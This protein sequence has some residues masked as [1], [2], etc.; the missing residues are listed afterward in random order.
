MFTE[1]VKSV[2]EDADT[3]CGDIVK[4]KV[5]IKVSVS[6]G[7]SWGHMTPVDVT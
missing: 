7:T 3:L 6:V 5:P 4:L 1:I 2:M